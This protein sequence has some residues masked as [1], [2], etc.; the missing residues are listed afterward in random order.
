MASYFYPQI[1]QIDADFFRQDFTGWARWN[2][3][4]GHR[5]KGGEGTGK[6]AEQLND[7]AFWKKLRK[8]F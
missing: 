6:T 4:G 3:G 1:T 5:A 2:K 7:C 8:N